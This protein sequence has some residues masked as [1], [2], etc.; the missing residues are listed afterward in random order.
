L[1]TAKALRLAQHVMISRIGT[2][3][4]FCYAYELIY[5]FIDGLLSHDNSDIQ[6]VRDNDSGKFFALV[7]LVCDDNPDVH[8]AREDSGKI[9][10]Y[11]YKLTV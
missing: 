1:Q 5:S 2:Q 4:D 11:L 3:V 6:S 7:V 10:L 9:L 8:F